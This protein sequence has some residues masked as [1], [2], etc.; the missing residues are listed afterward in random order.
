MVNCVDTLTLTVPTNQASSLKVLLA[1][2]SNI[3]KQPSNRIKLNFL[4]QDG[5]LTA[6]ESD[7]DLLALRYTV[8][9]GPLSLV[10]HISKSRQEIMNEIISQCVGEYLDETY[11]DVIEREEERA[12]NKQIEEYLNTLYKRLVKQEEKEKI[13]NI[14]QEE[15]NRYMSQMTSELV[16]KRSRKELPTRERRQRMRVSP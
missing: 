15:I 6:I 2:A 12:V 1:Y 7:S 5:S 8:R 13:K 3:A 14:E 11:D 10:A 9:N 4:G 16:N